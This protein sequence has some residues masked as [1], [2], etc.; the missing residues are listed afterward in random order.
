MVL[1]DVGTDWW[2]KGAMLWRFLKQYTSGEAKKLVLS[3]DGNNGWEAWKRLHEQFEPSMAMK[4]A[5][6][7]FQF[8]SLIG[9]RAKTAAETRSLMIEF[10]E[11]AKRIG[12]VTGEAVDERHAKSVLMGILD[13]ETLKHVGPFMKVKEPLDQTIRKIME[14]VNL[15]GGL[16]KGDPMELGRVE[17]HAEQGDQGAHQEE[18]DDEGDYW[19]QADED[20]GQINGLGEQ[21]Y[22]CNGSGHMH[23]NAHTLKGKVKER[24]TKA[25]AKERA[26]QIGVEKDNKAQQEKET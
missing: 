2:H 22:N 19:G 6:V 7:Q 21:C 20:W 15:T 23:E 8:T 5:Q 4:D 11:K 17:G 25:K 14:F 1:L 18:Q 13:M 9:R 10:E 3:V 16:G 12:E 26:K 24:A